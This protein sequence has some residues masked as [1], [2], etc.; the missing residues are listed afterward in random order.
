MPRMDSRDVGFRRVRQVRRVEVHLRGETYGYLRE[1]T[2]MAPHGSS[3]CHQ[4]QIS[5]SLIGKL[6]H[7]NYAC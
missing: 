5:R 6:V 4:K 2:G 3:G 7:A 1:S